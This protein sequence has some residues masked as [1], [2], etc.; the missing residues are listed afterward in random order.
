M[1]DKWERKRNRHKCWGHAI[2]RD[3]IFWDEQPPILD[4]LIDNKPGSGSGVVDWNNTLGLRS[5]PYKTLLVFYT[6]Y[7]KGSC[8]AYSNDRGRTWIRHPKNPILPPTGD[9]RDPNVFWYAPSNEW[10][11]V[12]FEK[13]GDS[14]GFNFY[15]SKNLLDW[16]FLSRVEGFYE[17][18]DFFELPVEGGEGE[19]KWVLMS[20]NGAY[21]IGTFDG[22]TFKPES[23][24]LRTEVGGMFYAPQTWKKT[25]DGQDSLMQMGFLRYPLEPRLTWHDQMTFPMKLTLRKLSEG[26]RVCR[27]PIDEIATLWTD[28]HELHDL[29]VHPG[30]NP[31]SNLHGDLF[32]IRADIEAVNATAFGLTLRGESVRYSV[33]D[34]KLTSGKG[35]A[36]V[37]LR[38]KHLHLQILLDR[39]SIEVFP[40]QG[41]VSLSRTFF[42]DPAN[43]DLGL[44]TEGGDIHVISLQVNTLESVWNG[45]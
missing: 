25:I 13:K 4:P 30:D 22:T 1:F 15:G 32:D 17:C 37:K 18:P 24:M 5:G 31:L 33:P 43:K 23:E 44:F 20:A 39:S 38:D 7:H 9:A 34:E 28:R 6:D 10:R 45:K 27:Q 16:K 14:D 19:R 36:I 26:I 21:Q 3:G 8:I 42:P 40:D 35:S 2:S 29:S 11:M 41:Q 12:R